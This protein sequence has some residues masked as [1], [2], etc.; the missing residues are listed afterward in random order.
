MGMMDKMMVFMMGRMSKEEK[1][2]RYFSGYT[3]TFWPLQ[4]YLDRR[5]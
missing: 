5:P 4:N 3:N 2:E 1:Q